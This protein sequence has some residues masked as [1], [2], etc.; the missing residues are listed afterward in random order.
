MTSFIQD[1]RYGLRS[2]AKNPG[3]TAVAVLTLALGVGANAAIFSVLRAVVL[4]DLPY[5]E[6]D[7]MA[8]MWTR[9]IRQNLPDGSS[10]LNFRDWKTQSKEFE[11]MA[12]YVRPEFTRGTLSGGRRAG[13]HLR[14]RGRT[15]F[16]QL[17][18][19]APLLGRA[20]RPATSPPRPV[21]RRDQPQPVAAALRCGPE[22]DRQTIEVERHERRDRRRHAARVRAAHADD[23]IVAATVLRPELARGRKPRLATASS[24]SAGWARR[25][26][27][28]GTRGDGHDRR[29]SARQ[30]PATNA[31]LRCDHG[32]AV[33]RVIG[34][35]TNVVVAALRL[36]R[37]RAADRLRQRREP[38]AGPLGGAPPRVLA[39]DVARREQD[40]ARAPGADRKP[41]CWRCWP[42]RPGCSWR[43][44]ERVT[45]GH[46]AAGRAAAGRDHPA[47]RAAFC[48]SS[49]PRRSPAV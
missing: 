14:R 23:R 28:V 9:N 11:D 25:Q 30:Y 24:S 35:T 3:F 6:A 26:D 34:R 8:V 1:L 20:S 18:G 2:L 33:D 27:R 44:L 21:R 5:H 7:R 46:L 32:P 10:Y 47:R 31:S 42:A 4:R 17:L 15:G 48:S 49:W 19:T 12:A 40:A 13:A 43:G 22:R 29:A 39:P 36:G 16:F 45:S 37:I 41:R 38:R